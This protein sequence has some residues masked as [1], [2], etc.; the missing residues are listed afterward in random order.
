M[1]TLPFF[2][3][4][5]KNMPED[6]QNNGVFLFP[7]CEVWSEIHKTPDVKATKM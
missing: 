4:S 1:V 3:L 5:E 2:F 7:Q 6:K